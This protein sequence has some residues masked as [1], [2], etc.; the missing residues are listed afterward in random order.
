MLRL[1]SRLHRAGL[2]AF[3]GLGVSLAA[4]AQPRAGLDARLDRLAEGLELTDAQES[5]LSALA[6]RYADADPA[7]LWDATSDL[8]DV[9][10]VRVCDIADVLGVRICDLVVAVLAVI[11]RARETRRV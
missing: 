6:Q 7:T 10:G 5:Q 8:A 2:A 1:S 3:L 9:L 11:T 4:D